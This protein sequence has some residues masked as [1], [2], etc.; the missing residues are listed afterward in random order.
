MEKAKIQP[1]ATPNPLNRSSPKLACVIASWT[2]PGMQNIVAIGLRVS[3]PQIR[4]FAEPLGWLVFCSFFW[5]GSSIRLQP[6][7]LDGYL[8]KIRKMTSFPVRK[9]FWGSRW[10]YFLFGPLNFRK[11]AI[12]GTDFDWATFLRPKIALRWVCSNINY[13]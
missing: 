12:L 10:L 5:G 3:A 8:R 1:L 6:T 2:A 4:D 9:C 11:T 13:P 7:L